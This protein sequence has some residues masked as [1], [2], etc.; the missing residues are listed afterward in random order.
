MS[1]YRGFNIDTEPSNDK[2]TWRRVDEEHSVT[3]IIER[4]MY[5]PA[6]RLFTLSV[7]DNFGFM[8]LVIGEYHSMARAAEAYTEWRNKPIADKVADKPMLDD[9]R[10]TI[11]NS[12]FN[13]RELL[14]IVR[15]AMRRYKNIAV[16]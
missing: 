1:G 16:N 3:A 11:E 15:S 8:R 7:C 14:L 6:D 12:D 13:E 5:G 2:Y 10:I 4:P 9:I